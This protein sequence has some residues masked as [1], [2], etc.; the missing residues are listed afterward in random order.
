MSPPRTTKQESG[1]FRPLGKVDL[2]LQLLAGT[3]D[4]ENW[5]SAGVRHGSCSA[6]SAGEQRSAGA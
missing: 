5:L 3:A 1:N 6:L 4:G 2:S